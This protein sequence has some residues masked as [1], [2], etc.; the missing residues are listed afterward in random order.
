MAVKR[1]GEGADE[2]AF[3]SERGALAPEAADQVA[4]EH[5]V[6]SG[7][8]GCGADYQRIVGLAGQILA[9][10]LPLIGQ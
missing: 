5:A 8:V 1:G 9:V 3:K 4:D 2:R 7:G 10:E 6:A